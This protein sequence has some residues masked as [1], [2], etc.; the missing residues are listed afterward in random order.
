M[1]PVLET[2]RLILRPLT[3]ADAPAVQKYFNNWNVI[4][5]MGAQVPWPYPDDGA[6]DFLKNSSLPRMAKGE[7]HVWAMTLKPDDA[8]IGV[9]EFRLQANAEGHRGFWLAEHLWGQGLMS[10]ATAAVNDFVFDVLGFDE[11]IETNAEWNVAS[12]ELKKKSGAVFIEAIDKP[13]PGGGTRKTETWRI[14]R[15]GWKG[16]RRA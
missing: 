3:I 1:T 7:A 8:C 2:D 10:E 12:R 15:D 6:E 4:K 13:Q 14:T 11:F 16:A 5:N 9:M